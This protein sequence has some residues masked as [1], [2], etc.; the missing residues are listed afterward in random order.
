MD[1]FITYRSCR[2]LDGKHT[3]FGKLVGGLDTLNEME[4]IE[5][6][7]K[8]RPIEDIIV[9]KAHIFVDPFQEADEMLAKERA[10]E[11]EKQQKAITDEKKRKERTQPLKV[12]RTGIGKYLNTTTVQPSTPGQPTTSTSEPTAKRNKPSSAHGFGNFGS[13]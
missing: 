2:H 8:D 7:N 5:V 9:E 13:W 1:S 4:K 3:I 10:D 12:F 11:V 6:D